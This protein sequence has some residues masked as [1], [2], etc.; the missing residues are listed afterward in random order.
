[1]TGKF[2]IIF[3]IFLATAAT[4]TGQNNQVL[5]FMN[6]PQNHLLNPALR[7][8]NSVYIGLPALSGISLNINNNF[9]NFSDVI[10]KGA[11][12]SLITFMHP[13][14]NPDDFLS[15]IKN[16]NSIE[17]EYMVQLL[18]LGF[19]LGKNNYF[20]L[21]INERVQGNAVIPGD[22]F[23][24]ALNG[25]ESFAG[26]KI[27]LSSL[28]WDMKSYHEVGM[29]F[30]R[31]FSS[32]LR[33]GVKGKALFGIAAAALK[34]RSLGILVG[35]D[36]SH[37]I[38]ADISLNLSAPVLVTMNNEN[39]IEGVEW[40]DTRFDNRKE[41]KRFLTGSGN[42]GLG[43]D[44]GATYE[45][46]PKLIASA[47]ITDIGY[48]KWKKDVTN[49]STDNSFL[50]SGLD[51]TG[52]MSGDQ[53]FDQVGQE[54]LDSLKNAFKITDAND[55]FTTFLP[56]GVTL[57]GS[58]NVT[59]KISLGV[60]SYSRFIGKQI[61][62]S[63]TLSANVNLGNAFSTSLSYTASNHR[64]DN[65]GAGLAFR[66]GVFQFY[67]LTDRI[68]LTWNRLKDGDNSFILPASWNNVSLRL[69]MNLVFGNRI[70]KKDDK[71]MIEC[72]TI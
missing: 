63:V 14:Y 11:K 15:K 50:F 45:V 40:D 32:R 60:L 4:S 52:V 26:N 65:L 59:R 72:I 64:F 62:E 17:Q 8:S 44:L 36:Y 23:K 54:L 61:R 53:S 67:M 10:L 42:F 34:N 24:L 41:L 6:L 20:F 29:G 47:S 56:F 58:Y 66:A 31:D 55:P 30:S 1:M 5:Y 18:G 3:I 46:T 70:K 51:M 37:T 28:R 12:D 39:N 27:D 13:D 68:P 57:G 38:D 16:K 48:I 49:L 35:N 21:D 69:G 2:K 22:L 9:V 25:N 43:I 71:P 33:I 7:P 19:S